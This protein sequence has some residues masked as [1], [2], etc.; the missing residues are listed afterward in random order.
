MTSLLFLAFLCYNKFEGDTLKNIYYTFNNVKKDNSN[1]ISNGYYEE[2]KSKFY[3]YIFNIENES[4]ANQIILNIKKQNKDA[5]H[6]V[7]IYSC[8]E[9][10]QIKIR[11]SDDG[12]PQGTATRAI[13]DIISKENITNICIVIVRYF[14]GIL[15][16]AGPLSRAYLN[17][18]RDASNKCQIEKLLIYVIKTIYT[19]YTKISEIKNILSTYESNNLVIIDEIVYNT[20]IQVKLK[21]EQDYENQVLESINNLI[22]KK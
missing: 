10:N 7:Y 5:R 22:I 3:S 11:F 13:Y 18:Y 6:V 21:I 12:E 8:V 15:L 16:G 4:D 14:G 20:D 1:E 17:S 2:K 9:N 19:D